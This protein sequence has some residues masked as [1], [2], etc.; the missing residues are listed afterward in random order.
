MNRQILSSEEK[1]NMI[2]YG[3]STPS[4]KNGGSIQAIYPTKMKDCGCK[5]K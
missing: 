4:V 1:K 5:K 3:K 2:S